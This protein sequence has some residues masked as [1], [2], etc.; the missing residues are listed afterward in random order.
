VHWAPPSLFSATQP[1]A[2]ALTT[3]LSGWR[4]LGW[5]L[6]KNSP[7]TLSRPAA[8]QNHT[9]QTLPLKMHLQG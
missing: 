5:P 1:A 9:P 2:K 7:L 6:A 4:R 3:L 8:G